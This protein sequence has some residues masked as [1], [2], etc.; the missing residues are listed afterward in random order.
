MNQPVTCAEFEI[1]LA[2]FLDGTLRAEEKTAVEN[3][4]AA[5]AACAELAQDVSGAMAFMERSAE[6]VPPPVLVTQILAAT[7]AARVEAAWLERR[8]QSARLE[9][10]TGSRL[11][12]WLGW[13]WQPRFAMG[14]AMAAISIAMLSRFGPAA[15]VGMQR[16]WDRAVKNYDTMQVVYDVRNQWQEWNQ[17]NGA[18]RR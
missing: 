6:V 2:D 15:Q 4:Q 14:L 12:Q 3:H 7:A 18:E 8:T 13:V 11:K 10:S 9:E 1:L 5:C 17:E 16:A